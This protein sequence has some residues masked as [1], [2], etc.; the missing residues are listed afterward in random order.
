MSTQRLTDAWHGKAILVYTTREQI[1]LKLATPMSAEKLGRY[2]PDLTQRGLRWH[3]TRLKRAKIIEVIRHEPNINGS[4]DWAPVYFRTP[5]S[6]DPLPHVRLDRGER[7]NAV[8]KETRD[9]I[10]K[11]RRETY[12]L[13]HPK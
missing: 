9:R 2:F 10:N 1:V 4:G 11:K 5:D 13:R 3:L 12:R 6:L 7:S 8:A